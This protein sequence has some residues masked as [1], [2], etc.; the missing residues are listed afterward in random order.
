MAGWV[1][2][3]DTAVGLNCSRPG[4]LLHDRNSVG[5]GSR[6]G[7]IGSVRTIANDAGAIVSTMDYGPYGALGTHLGASDSAFGFASAWT[8]PVSGTDYLRAREYDP[9]TGQFLQVD[10]AVNVTHEPY[11]YVAGDPLASVDPLG[12]CKGMDGTPQDRVCTGNDFF[13]GQDLWK[14][15]GDD[16]NTLNAGFTVVRPSALGC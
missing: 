15:L 12:L 3:G 9:V 16:L 11:A 5:G 1:S 2:G 13:W 14:G 10:P 7:P 6:R 8:D 4:R